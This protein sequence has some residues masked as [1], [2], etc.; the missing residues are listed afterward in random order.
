MVLDSSQI[1][2][3]G[4]KRMP[5]MV[6]GRIRGRATNVSRCWEYCGSGRLE[7]RRKGRND[8][9]RFGCIHVEQNDI[10]I[11]AVMDPWRDVL[12]AE[13]CHPEHDR[14]VQN[15]RLGPAP[16]G[17]RAA[18]LLA[19]RILDEMQLSSCYN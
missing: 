9:K 7:F 18:I 15:K 5:M 10:K 2:M 14:S 17:K 3:K 1:E 12:I 4:L 19:F 6:E 16:R 8:A 13:D 11:H